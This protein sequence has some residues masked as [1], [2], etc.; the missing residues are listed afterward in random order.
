[1]VMKDEEEHSDAGLQLDKT[2]QI[3]DP[4]KTGRFLVM[5]NQNKDP[6]VVFFVSGTF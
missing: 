2:G 3:Q 4:T 5:Q 6:G 1:M